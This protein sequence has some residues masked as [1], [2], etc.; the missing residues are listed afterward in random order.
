[1]TGGKA[2]CGISSGEYLNW[3]ARFGLVKVWSVLWPDI[4][5]ENPQ[6]HRQEMIFI[7]SLSL[8]LGSMHATSRM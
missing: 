3:K 4:A 8:I 5:I 6:K 1:M 7:M 2:I